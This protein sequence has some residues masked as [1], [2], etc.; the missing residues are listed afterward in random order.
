M[1]QVAC[2]FSTWDGTLFDEDWEEK[3]LTVVLVSPFN[4][5]LGLSEMTAGLF[6]P[7]CFTTTISEAVDLKGAI[8]T[9]LTGEVVGSL[10]IGFFEGTTGPMNLFDVWPMTFGRLP[11]DNCPL[12]S[13]AFDPL[14]TV[15]FKTR[16]GA[17][18]G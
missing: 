10:N 11:F 3:V 6:P 9:F 12:T 1:P 14:M 7:F 2:Y 4:L 18:T 8:V 17:E 16:F 5:K 13:G 15:E